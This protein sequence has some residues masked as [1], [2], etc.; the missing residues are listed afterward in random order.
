M[1]SKLARN[2]VCEGLNVRKTQTGSHQSALNKKA[3]I[4]QAR[5]A[6]RRSFNQQL[7]EGM[8]DF[9][10]EMAALME[11]LAESE[12]WDMD[13][14]WWERDRSYVLFEEIEQRYDSV[15]DDPY[16]PS[17]DWRN[18]FLYSDSPMW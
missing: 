4:K 12:R 8:E 11:E 5:R 16:D 15:Y 2:V 14:D 13:R 9:A 18:D 17:E 3:W 1:S 6:E 7:H 10:D